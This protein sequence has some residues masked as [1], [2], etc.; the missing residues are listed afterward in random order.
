VSYGAVQI[1]SEGACLP[2]AAGKKGVKVS[3]G[4]LRLNGLE[5][6]PDANVRI[7]LSAKD[8]TIDTTGRVTVQL[9]APNGPIVLFRGELHIKLPTS[10]VGAKLASF[11]TAKFPVDI[12]G[13][14]V[15]GDVDVILK[16]DAVEIP[17][18]ITLPKALGGITGATT[19]RADNKRGLHIDSVGFKVDRILLG[20]LILRNL[21]VSWTGSTD[22]WSGGGEITVAGVGMELRATFVR[23]AFNEGFVKVTPVPFPG[24]TLFTDV[25]LNSVSGRLG[26]DPTF[27]EAGALVGFQAVS[28]PDTYVLGVNATLRVTIKPLFAI[29]FRGSGKLAIFPVLEAHIHGDADGYFF[30]RANAELDL[31]DIV[32]ARG[33]FDGFFDTSKGTFGATMRLNGCLGEPP[34][35]ACSGFSATVSSNGIAGCLGDFI[36]FGYRWGRGGE[37]L[38]P[39]SCDLGDYEL[40]SR[41]AGARA[42]QAAQSFTLAG[43][44]P[45]A[46]VKLTG[47]GGTPPNVVLVSPSGARLTPVPISAPNASSAPA[48]IAASGNTAH[49]GLRRP[50]GGAWRVEPQD[51]S[52]VTQISVANGLSAPAISTRVGGRGRKRVLVYRATR[53]P[54]LVVRFYEKVGSGARQIGVASAARGRIRFTAGDGRGGRRAIVA[55]AEQNGLPR[56]LRNVA[57]YRAPGPI[58]RK[59]VR[60]LRVRRSGRTAGIRWRR[61]SGAAAYVVRITVSDGRKLLRVVTGRRVRVGG[62]ARGETVRVSVAGRS[63]HA[64]SGKAARARLKR[65]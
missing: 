39:P 37:L 33:G 58:R 65:R 60:G 47:S 21:E 28:P 59:R 45:S 36:G 25:F 24:V 27:I 19:L 57:S 18:S 43:G 49:V 16:E 31:A 32:S 46:S 52:E 63:A 10:K 11:D 5:I 15:S 41:A 6:V 8:R 54:G 22:T 7:L 2:N 1:L 30:A 9:R 34:L 23:G 29:D 26:I 44:L 50:A 53:R 42:A 56:L 61:S 40:K 12:K 20:P 64:R 55:M 62:I 14:G 13:F 35:G 17:I 38:G 48:V 4:T 51:G 3:E